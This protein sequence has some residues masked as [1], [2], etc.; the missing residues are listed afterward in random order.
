[1]PR[2]QRQQQEF[3]QRHASRLTSW[4]ALWALGLALITTPAG[5]ADEPKAPGAATEEWTTWAA[6]ILEQQLTGPYWLA[7]DVQWNPRA[8]FVARAGLSYR[9]TPGVTATLGYA[10]GRTD[11]G[12][13]YLDR[14]E[15]R[16]WAQILIPFQLGKRWS[17]SERLRLEHRIRENIAHGDVTEGYSQ[18]VRWRAQT[19]VT[20]WLTEPNPDRWFLQAALELLIQ[21]AGPN[22][23][24]QNRVSLL[25]GYELKPVTLRLGY[26]NRF[27]P[28]PSGLAPVSENALLLWASYRFERD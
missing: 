14:N 20:F 12:T 4:L 21:N 27:I 13:G 15:H 26:M 1:V 23:L 8:F 17:V 24:D 16:P 7:A 22:Y 10:Y 6:V 3:P 5:A 9:F 19:A 25:V 2:S 18:F 11:P 28:G